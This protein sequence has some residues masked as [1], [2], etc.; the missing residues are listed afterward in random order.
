MG[1]PLGTLVGALLTSKTVW[2]VIGS[3]LLT[4]LL[5][6]YLLVNSVSLI[7]MYL[8]FADA[9]AYVSQARTAECNNIKI[10]IDALF[11]ADSAF[12]SEIY[13]LVEALRDKAAEEIRA[14]YDNNQSGYDGYEVDDEYETVLKP[15]LSQYLAVLMEETWNGKQIEGFNG[16]G[17]GGPALPTRAGG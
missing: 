15:K 8:S 11:A 10:Q 9:D 17:T 1:G 3:I 2:K 7:F 16:Y 4:I 14:D 5:F 6:A 12:E 13:G